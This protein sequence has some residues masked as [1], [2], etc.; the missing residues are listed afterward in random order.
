MRRGRLTVEI[1]GSGNINLIETPVVEL[2][3][4]FEKYD[5]KTDDNYSNGLQRGFQVKRCSNFRSFRA[6]EGTFVIPPVTYSYYNIKQDRYVTLKSDNPQA[7][8][9]EK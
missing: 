5:V 2:P 9:A 1:S 7:E 3:H 4:D 6:G 8:G